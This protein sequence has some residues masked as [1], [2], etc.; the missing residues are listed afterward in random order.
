MKWKQVH[1][2][3]KHLNCKEGE[4]PSGSRHGRR[5]PLS[6]TASLRLMDRKHKCCLYMLQYNR[7]MSKG[8]QW[9][10]GSSANTSSV[11][12]GIHF[13][14]MDGYLVNVVLHVTQLCAAELPH[15]SFL[16]L[17]RSNIPSRSWASP[18]WPQIKAELWVI[19][20][21]CPEEAPPPLKFQLF[22][23][24]LEESD[25]V[26]L[27]IRITK[28][29]PERLHHHFDLLLFW[30]VIFTE[31]LENE[32]WVRKTPAEVFQSQTC[33]N[34]S[35]QQRNCW[36]GVTII[37]MCSKCSWNVFYVFTKLMNLSVA[38]DPSCGDDAGRVR[39][40]QIISRVEVRD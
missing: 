2:V 36:W 26:R 37:T 11:N 25:Q 32:E 15:G 1:G 29:Q 6:A 3:S 19:L 22:C 4:N 30:I 7:R 35:F 40:M 16:T 31:T 27:R 28:R 8:L 14:V 34:S 18:H 10:E 12:G 21:R 23:F 20:W 38:H 24:G 17:C 39:H 13:Q 33:C 9:L 5:A